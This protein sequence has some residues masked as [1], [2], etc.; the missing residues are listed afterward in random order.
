[1]YHSRG[2]ATVTLKSAFLGCGPRARKH[3]QAYELVTKGQIA[4]I[5]DLDEERLQAFGDDFCIERR[6]TEIHQML[7]EV[8][9]DLLHVVTPPTIRVDLL[10]IADD[11]RVPVV[12]V[13]KPI[14]VQGEDYRAILALNQRATTRYVVNTQLHFH[15]NNLLLKEYVAEG[16]IGALT[17]IDVSARSTMLDQG[18]HVLELAHSY[19]GFVPFSRVFGNVSGGKTLTS[20]QPAPDVAEAAIDFANG[21]RA[22]LVCG[23]IAP[24][25]NEYETIYA[26]KRIAAYGTRGWVHWKMTGWELFSERDGYASGE[27]SYA[28]QDD[29]AQAALTDA[30][31][32]WAADE[33]ALHP[34]RL[35]R[36]LQQFNVILGGYASALEGRPVDL[37][38]DPPDGMLEAFGKRL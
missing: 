37:P 3:A 7:D 17:F 27:H 35:E 15:P 30:A 21:V 32:E 14:A 33:T 5:C 4:A 29:R 34:T 2:E 19:N 25:A 23:T 8:Q 6:Y 26:H 11:H 12:I 31:F 10:T 9:P 38:F 16:K 18:V 22:Q 1:M 28:E 36:N 20:R 13:E 24:V